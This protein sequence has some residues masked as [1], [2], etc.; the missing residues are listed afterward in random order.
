VNPLPDLQQVINWEES[1]WRCFRKNPS[2]I[3]AVI[4]NN[5]LKPDTAK[6][7]TDSTKYQLDDF[8]NISKE[9]FENLQDKKLDSF[10]I[11]NGFDAKYRA[12]TVKEL[13]RND[14]L[15]PSAVYDWL[16]A[17]DGFQNAGI[18]GCEVY[19]SDN[20]GQ[21]WTKVNTKEISTFSTYGYY[22]A[23]ISLSA[24]DENKVVVLGFNCILS[25]DGGKQFNATDKNNTHPDWHACWIDPNRD[26]H[27]IAQ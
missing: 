4:D 25:K 7:K 14:K 3:Y 16:V 10:L 27:W 23:K 20:E 9:N 21:T 13:I 18:I 24:T 6:K 2:I 11:K 8:K 5:N 12:A 1:D 26:G 15:K 19:R 17:D 22:F